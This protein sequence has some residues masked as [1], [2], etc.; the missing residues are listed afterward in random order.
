VKRQMREAWVGTREKFGGVLGE[1]R[2]CGKHGQRVG[3][4]VCICA[5]IGSCRVEQEAVV[6]LDQSQQ[7]V[8][9]VQELE[10]LEGPRQRTLQ[11]WEEEGEGEARSNDFLEHHCTCALKKTT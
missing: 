2:R 5:L 4:G 9:D 10:L 8:R 11:R 1:G 3:D 7:S 6:G